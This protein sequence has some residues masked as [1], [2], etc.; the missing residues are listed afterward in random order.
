MESQTQRRCAYDARNHSKNRKSKRRFG[1]RA[2]FDPLLGRKRR[3]DR[4]RSVCRRRRRAGR[5]AREG[6]AYTDVPLQIT[7]GEITGS[8]CEAVAAHFAGLPRENRIV[9]ELGPGMNPNVTDLCGYTLLDE[10]MAGT[11][12]IAVGANT[13]FGGEKP[14]DGPCRLRRPRR[15]GGA[16]MTGKKTAEMDRWLEEK[17]RRCGR[18]SQTLRA[19]DRA[20]EAV[21]EKIRANVHDIFRTV[22]SVAEK[23]LAR[24]TT[25]Y[26][27]VKPE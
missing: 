25:G 16:G 5:L 1:R 10:K 26:W 14:G 17:I 6:E 19:D 8:S 2:D 24:D 20:D 15:S 3:Q 18:R 21:F 27:R 4:R 22:L 11:F 23:L 9:C 7:N 13:M 12:H